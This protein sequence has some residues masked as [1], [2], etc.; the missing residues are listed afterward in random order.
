MRAK[1]IF[2]HLEVSIGLNGSPTPLKAAIEQA[3]INSFSILPIEAAELAEDRVDKVAELINKRQLDLNSQGK[4]A[5]LCIIGSSS[6]IVAGSCYVFPTDELTVAQ[7][8][9]HRIHATSLHSHIRALTFQEFELFGSKVLRELG[10]IEATVTPHSN[11]QGIDFFG[12]VSFAQFHDAPANFFQLAHEV[13]IRLAGQAK[14]YPQ[15]AIGTSIVRELIGSVSLARTKTFSKDYDPFETMELRP[16]SPLVCLLF[17]SGAFTSG[18]KQLAL[19]A[20]VIAKDGLQ[21]ATFLADRG[22][23]MIASSSGSTFDS[24]EFKKW[25]YAT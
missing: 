25:L 2:E 12:K 6:D 23:G 16:F 20:G 15:N 24:A 3:L 18:A 8:K 14:H 1:Q 5:T 22:V 19:R 21:L 10:A 13:E 7:A 17:T 4:I 11:D 9:N